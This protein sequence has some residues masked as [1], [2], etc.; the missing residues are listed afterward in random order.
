MVRVTHREARVP[1]R[2]GLS[3][4]APFVLVGNP[5]STK[6]RGKRH[7]SQ[8]VTDRVSGARRRKGQNYWYH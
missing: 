8:K 2:C 5:Y 1:R 6:C 4:W 3:V 7:L